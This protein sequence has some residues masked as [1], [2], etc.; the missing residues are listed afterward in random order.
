MQFVFKR[1]VT[2]TEGRLSPLKCKACI[3]CSWT[4]QPSEISSSLHLH[5]CEF[6][7]RDK[8]YNL[9]RKPNRIWSTNKQKQPRKSS[10]RTTVSRYWVLN[11]QQSKKF[12]VGS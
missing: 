10:D 6:I 1:S 11:L 3:Q 5:P 4:A 7:H 9:T 12:H 2:D 8:L